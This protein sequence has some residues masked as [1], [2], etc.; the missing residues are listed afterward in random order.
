MVQL[1]SRM[2]TTQ[3]VSVTSSSASIASVLGE[4]TRQVRVVSSVACHVKIGDGSLTA[5]TSDAYLPAA[6]VDYFTVTPGQS[7][8]FIRSASDG[9]AYVTEMS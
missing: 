8:A 1:S 4:Q 6:V 5:T 2:G 7:I 9:T 3:A